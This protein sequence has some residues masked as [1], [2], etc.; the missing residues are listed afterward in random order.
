[1]YMYHEGIAKRGPDEVCT[2]LYEYIMASIPEGVTELHLFCDGCGGQN[3]NNTFLRFLLALT[4]SGRFARIE[5]YFPV[6]GHSFLPCDRDFGLIKKRIKREDRLYVPEEYCSLV[7]ESR[8]IKPSKVVRVASESIL[9]FQSWWSTY[10]KKSTTSMRTNARAG[11]K[12]QITKYYHFEFESESRGCLIAHPYID[13]AEEVLYSFSKST[14]D[15]LLPTKQLYGADGVPI[16]AKKLADINR[17]H[18]YLPDEHKEF[19]D[20]I[21]HWNAVDGD[22]DSESSE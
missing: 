9:D 12:F 1:M 8:S 19:Y 5:S 4:A 13:S 10:Y 22:D 3:R 14:A 6:R 11:L 2:F 18:R 16:K 20:R 7:E 15:P 17:L 21:S